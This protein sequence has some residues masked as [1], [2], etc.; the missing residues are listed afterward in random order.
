T[1]TAGSLL[2]AVAAL[3]GDEATGAVFGGLELPS[4]LEPD[5]CG[6]G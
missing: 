3:G 5:C 2:L 1:W 6:Q 4:G